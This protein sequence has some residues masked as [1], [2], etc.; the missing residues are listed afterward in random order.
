MRDAKL[1]PPRFADDISTFT[2]TS[3]TTA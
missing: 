1:S 3:R 2:A